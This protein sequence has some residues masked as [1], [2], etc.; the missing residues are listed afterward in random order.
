VIAI[1][2]LEPNSAAAVLL[3]D[4]SGEFIP[5]LP[6]DKICV[7]FKTASTSTTRNL[8]TPDVVINTSAA[9]A[10]YN[11]VPAVPKFNAAAVAE[12]KGNELTTVLVNVVAVKVVLAVPLTQFNILGVAVKAIPVVAPP[13]NPNEG[14]AHVLAGTAIGYVGVTVPVKTTCKL[15]LLSVRNMRELNTPWVTGLVCV[16]DVTR[17]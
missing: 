13:L 14:A 5:E 16:T 9:V 8:A 7:A 1:E 3:K 11:P 12:P 2:A 15:P 4:I 6:Q 17:R 10:A